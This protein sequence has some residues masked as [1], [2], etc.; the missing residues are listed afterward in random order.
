MQI[1][2]EICID[3]W[4]LRVWVRQYC[5]S[6]RE[7]SAGGLATPLVP[8]LQLL[9]SSASESKLKIKILLRIIIKIV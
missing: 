8:L 5:Y 4:A 1:A 3:P 2:Q 9:A 6:H 7:T